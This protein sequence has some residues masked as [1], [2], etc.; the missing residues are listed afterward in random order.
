LDDLTK[1]LYAEPKTKTTQP[2]SQQGITMPNFDDMTNKQMVDWI[3]TNLGQ[4]VS[5][6]A[7]PLVNE[8]TQ[9]KVLQ[10]MDK[11]ERK[12]DDYSLYEEDIMKIAV[13][14]PSLSIEEAYKLAKAEDPTRGEG[15]KETGEKTSRTKT[16][17]L[18]NLPSRGSLGDKSKMPSNLVQENKVYSL[19]EAAKAAFA[20]IQTGG[21]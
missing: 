5:R 19:E 2:A 4:V 6:T 15:V 17:R 18:L 21:K 1:D 20:K 11:C 12:H 10:E 8:I 9:L 7:Q 16:E 14:K 13:K 3:V